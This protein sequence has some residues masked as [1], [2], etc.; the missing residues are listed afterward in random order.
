MEWLNELHPGWAVPIG[1]V[2][3]V[4]LIGLFYVIPSEILHRR[5][6]R[7]GEARM[8]AEFELKML[9]LWKPMHPNPSKKEAAIHLMYVKEQVA[10]LMA[11]HKRRCDGI[12]S[13]TP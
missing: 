8:I 3:G 13:D 10:E 11:Q 6:M 5:R 2:G 12:Y 4:A 9:E 1:L 7:R